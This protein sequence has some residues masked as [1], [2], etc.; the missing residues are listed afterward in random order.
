M[1]PTDGMTGRFVF[2]SVFILAAFVL[3]KVARPEFL[4]SAKATSLLAWG[5]V[6]FFGFV[7]TKTCLRRAKCVGMPLVLV[8]PILL[9]LV[10]APIAGSVLSGRDLVAPPDWI[11]WLLVVSGTG[12]IV[13][14]VVAGEQDSLPRKT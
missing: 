7:L 9:G 6:L 1:T 14:L 8:T 4:M 2:S 10:I 12:S 13:W 5:V 3:R 11:R